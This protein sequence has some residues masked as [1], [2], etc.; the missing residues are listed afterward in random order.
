[1]DVMEEAPA[2]RRDPRTRPLT[3]VAIGYLPLWA[4]IVV[5]LLVELDVIGPL[6]VGVVMFAAFAVFLVVTEGRWSRF[7]LHRGRATPRR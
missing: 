5:W 4:S 3:R 1:M 6:V 2:M 7:R